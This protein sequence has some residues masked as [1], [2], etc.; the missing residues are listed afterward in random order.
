MSEIQHVISFS[1]GKD[2][3]ALLFLMLEKGCKINRIVN[4]DTSKEFPEMYEH[5]RKVQSMIPIKI[6]HVNFNFDY[7]FGEHVKTRG[8]NRGKRGYGWPSPL[9]R[10]C[11]ALKREAFDRCLKSPVNAHLSASEGEDDESIVKSLETPPDPRRTRN[12]G[13]YIIYTGIAADEA[14][15]AQKNGGRHATPLIDWG[16]TEKEALSYCNSLGFDWGG[17][18]R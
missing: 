18:I 5:I 7:W 1:G 10:W 4:V 6:E 9:G 12:S 8:K 16:I 3:T 15:R 13:G 2:S 14:H 17:A 11:T